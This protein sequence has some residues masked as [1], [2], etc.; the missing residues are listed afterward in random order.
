MSIRTNLPTVPTPGNNQPTSWFQAW[1][2]QGYYFRY[3]ALFTIAIGVC[4][5][6]T[7]FFVGDDIL[8][9]RIVTPQFDQLFAIPMTYAGVAGILSW[10]RMQ[11]RNAWHKA[12]VGFIVFYIAV[13]IPLHLASYFTNSTEYLRFVP[14]WFSAVLQPY[15]LATL[16]T[17]WRLQF[18]S[19]PE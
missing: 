8:V 18:K 13:S 9:Q 5:H 7:R 11:F 17:L 15:Y 14:L 6:I 16:I 10:R 2:R 19:N 12:F 1:Q 4:L 3:A